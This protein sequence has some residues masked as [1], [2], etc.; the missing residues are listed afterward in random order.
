MVAK[1]KSDC[2]EIQNKRILFIFDDI[3]NDKEFKFHSSKLA[4]FATLC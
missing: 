3:L 2:D 1:C 4:I